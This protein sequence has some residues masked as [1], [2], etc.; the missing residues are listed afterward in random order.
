MKKIVLQGDTFIVVTQPL[1]TTHAIV[2]PVT[3]EAPGSAKS[4]NTSK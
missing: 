2:A 1:I 4:K 3:T